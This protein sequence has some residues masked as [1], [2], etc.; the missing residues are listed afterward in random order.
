MR[1]RSQLGAETRQ[2]LR[3]PAQ[4]G[5]TPAEQGAGKQREGR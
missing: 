2:E 3:A 1:G 4:V 5:A